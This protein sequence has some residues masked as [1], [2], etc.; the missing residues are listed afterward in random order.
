M[1]SV[2]SEKDKKRRSAPQRAQ[3]GQ[4]SQGKKQRVA[5][6]NRRYHKTGFAEYNNKYK[7]ID[8]HAKT[9]DDHREILV[10]VNKNIYK[11]KNDIHDFYA[12][13]FKSDTSR[14]FCG[15]P[16]IGFIGVVST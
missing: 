5:G 8:P 13:L 9:L 1:V 16:Y 2:Y 10:E 15:H 12:M 3:G 4:R 7:N 11:I 14:S 6:K